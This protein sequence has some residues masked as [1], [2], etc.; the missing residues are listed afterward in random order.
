MQFGA[1]TLPE[2]ERSTTTLAAQARAVRRCE[3]VKH[4]TRQD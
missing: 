1:F 4:R 3:A 2:K